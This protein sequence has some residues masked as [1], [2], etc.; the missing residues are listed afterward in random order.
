[1]DNLLTFF[2]GVEGIIVVNH[3]GVPIRTTL[4]PEITVQV[5]GEMTYFDLHPHLT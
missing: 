1:M 2:A 5:R 3:E 4:D